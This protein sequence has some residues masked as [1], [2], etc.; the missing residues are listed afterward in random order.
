[1]GSGGRGTVA[2][3][4]RYDGAM[5]IYTRSGDAGD[6]GLFGGGR[7]R[8]DALRVVAYGSVDEANAAIGWARAHLPP[9]LADVDDVLVAAQNRLFDVGA[10]LSAPE[11]VPARTHL[12]PPGLDDVAALESAIDRFEGELPPLSTFVLPAGA[13]SA[14]ALQ[15]A[16]AVVRR[17][18]RETVALAAREPLN[19]ALLPYL[20]RLS[21]LLFVLA[22]VVNLRAGVGDVPWAPR[23]R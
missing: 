6:T 21:D 23:G 18:E 11:G 22:R 7:V 4:R 20:N 3:G 14:A 19:P 15:V 16:R 10:D 1:V 8:K 12:H 2:A 5:K 17:A 13:P 9:G